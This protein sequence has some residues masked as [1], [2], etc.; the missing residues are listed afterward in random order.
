[1]TEVGSC[2]KDADRGRLPRPQRQNGKPIIAAKEHKERK[3]ENPQDPV[4]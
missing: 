2:A 1:M 3:E 4:Y